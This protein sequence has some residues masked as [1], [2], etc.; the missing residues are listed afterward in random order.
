M[1]LAA[2]FLLAVACCIYAIRLDG[3]DLILLSND[4]YMIETSEKKMFAAKLAPSIDML[5]R[6]L[7]QTSVEGYF[8]DENT[9]F[10]SRINEKLTRQNPR[11]VSSF[12]F[13]TRFL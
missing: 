13:F 4:E 11:P 10:V 6:T 7:L 8:H 5:E 3:V 2:L 9:F 1:K 12:L